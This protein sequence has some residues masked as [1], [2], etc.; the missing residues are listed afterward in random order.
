MDESGELENN[1]FRGKKL[2]FTDY[3][4]SPAEYRA[5]NRYLSDTGF[6]PPKVQLLE[7]IKQ[8]EEEYDHNRSQETLSKLNELRL[9]Y[10]IAR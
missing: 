5:I 6:I 9:K 4:R 3:F 2:D 1:P 7:E 8:L 10:N